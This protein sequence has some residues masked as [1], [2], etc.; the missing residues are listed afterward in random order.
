MDQYLFFCHHH[1]A[2]FFNWYK[3]HFFNLIKKLY[4]FCATVPPVETLSI[5]TILSGIISGQKHFNHEVGMYKNTH[6]Q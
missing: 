2:G 1:V 4:Q 6:L 5:V 3:K